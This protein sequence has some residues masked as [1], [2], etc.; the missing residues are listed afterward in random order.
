MWGPHVV[1][2]G[3]GGGAG[4]ACGEGP[5]QRLQAA[6]TKKEKSSELTEAPRNARASMGAGVQLGL[7]ECPP[8]AAAVD[9]A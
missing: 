7:S 8:Q 9:P 3:V 4:G 6:S 2:P 1:C 5:A